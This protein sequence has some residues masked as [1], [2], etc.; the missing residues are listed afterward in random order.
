M[1]SNITIQMQAAHA[2]TTRALDGV[3][4]SGNRPTD[5]R[6][7]CS[8]HY[9]SV[10]DWHI[11]LLGQFPQQMNCWWTADLTHAAGIFIQLSRM[12]AGILTGHQP[13]ED[14]AHTLAFL[15]ESKVIRKRQVKKSGFRN[16]AFDGLPAVP[17][18][19]SV[20]DYEQSPLATIP[21]WMAGIQH[22]AKQH[23]RL[24]D[25]NVPPVLTTP[26]F[27][28]DRTRIEPLP[29]E[30]VVQF[31]VEGKEALRTLQN[32]SLWKAGP[33][34]MRLLDS[35]VPR[36]IGDD[37]LDAGNTGASVHRTGVPGYVEAYGPV[38]R[39]VISGGADGVLQVVTTT[40]DVPSIGQ[41]AV[42]TSSGKLVAT[43]ARF[44]LL[45]HL[46]AR[47]SRFIKNATIREAFEAAFGD[48]YNLPVA[49]G[50][51]A[52]EA[53]AARYGATIIRGGQTTAA[54]MEDIKVLPALHNRWVAMRA[55][56]RAAEEEAN[57]P[58]EVVDQ[59]EAPS[60]ADLET[61][62]SQVQ[63]EEIVNDVM[64]GAAPAQEEALVVTTPAAEAAPAADAPKA[65]ARK[66]RK[67]AVVPTE[68]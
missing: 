4:R 56:A 48:W 19:V 62:A 8:A 41:K 26:D 50:P 33:A 66:G 13:C 15:E 39:M 27:Y 12:T 68:A 45:S 40:P 58:T 43:A 24:T 53:I 1:K 10:S 14:L 11:T 38:I 21:G 28:P 52:T 9:N 63:V 22:V 6:A 57:N 42:V 16:Q 20:R 59:V 51:D 55:A 17:Q 29:L 61:Q 30:L 3:Q 65:P 31:T 34:P 5:T 44:P 35:A 47:L 36:N 18:E 23:A 54:L 64:S 60:L 2:N 67:R 46:D 49:A 32:S 37:L 25:G 7:R